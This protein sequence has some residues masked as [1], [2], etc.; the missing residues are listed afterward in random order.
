[1]LA[2]SDLSYLLKRTLLLLKVMLWSCMLVCCLYAY[3]RALLYCFAASPF[4]LSF[5]PLVIIMLL[6]DIGALVYRDC[7]CITCFSFVPLSFVM[8]HNSRPDVCTV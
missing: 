3:K 8:V 6:G 5:R 2:V 7:F 1:M 4:H